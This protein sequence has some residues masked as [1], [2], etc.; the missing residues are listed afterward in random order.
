MLTNILMIMFGKRIL[1]LR[2][3]MNEILLQSGLVK[4]L[5]SQENCQNDLVALSILT[6]PFQK[7]LIVARS[8]PQSP[9]QSWCQFIRCKK[10]NLTWSR[11]PRNPLLHGYDI[12]TWTAPGRNDAA[13]EPGWGHGITATTTANAT[14]ASITDSISYYDYHH[15]HAHISLRNTSSDLIYL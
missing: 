8:Q 7:R 6:L 14:I 2:S 5:A 13:G 11:Y 12:S 10:S 3:E 15:Y 4:V 9:S 1:L